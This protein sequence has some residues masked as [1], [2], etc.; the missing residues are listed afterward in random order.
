MGERK[1]IITKLAE[2]KKALSVRIPVE[3]MIFFGS[4]AI[5]SKYKE[6]SDIDLVVVSPYFKGI[7][8]AR[9]KDLY[10]Y[11]NLDYPVD[12]IC[13]TPAEFEKLRKRVSL[14]SLA[15]EEGIE[16]A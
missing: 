4:R 11:W 10:G 14:V 3:K 5:G 13:Y 2:F 8:C 7:G 1:D 15:L 12:F 9:G 6:E 16:I